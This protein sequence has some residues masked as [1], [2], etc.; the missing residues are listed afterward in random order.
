M[1]TKY[2]TLILIFFFYSAFGQ[3][4]LKLS[5]K[6]SMTTVTI[7]NKSKENYIIPVDK[8]HFRPAET[9]CDS[10][11]DHESEFPSFGLVV[12]V[13]TPN[14]KRQSYVIGY[15]HFENFDSITA[16]FNVE[17]DRFDKKI[18]NWAKKNNIKNYNTAL[19]NYKLI[20]NLI[21]LKPDEKTT[22]R[23][24][25]DLKNITS[26]EL[27]FYNYILEESEN[28]ELYLSLCDF[29]ATKY[30]TRSQKRKFRSY[31]FFSGILESNKVKL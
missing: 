13:M 31:K 23:I 3:L 27:I 15:Q 2:Y 21:F 5:L 24:K 11:S 1:A 22:F 6:D 20:N 10:F 4:S 26:Q 16:K 29:D 19:I 30:L 8:S 12:N 14:D 9:Y 28:Y 25:L 17:R 18:K 7:H